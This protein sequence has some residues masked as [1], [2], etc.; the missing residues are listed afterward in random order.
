MKF[1]AILIIATMPLTALARIGET[2]E[3]C[4]KRYGKL[5]IPALASNGVEYLNYRVHGFAIG[6]H[7]FDS[8]CQKI[9]YNKEDEGVLAKSEIEALLSENGADWQQISETEWKN[10]ECSAKVWGKHLVIISDA[11]QKRIDAKK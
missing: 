1:L 4:D 7:I 11:Y 10:Q 9:K 5:V 8:T 2:K 3:Q 6:L